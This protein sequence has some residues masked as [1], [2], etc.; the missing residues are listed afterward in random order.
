MIVNKLAELTDTSSDVNSQI[1]YYKISLSDFADYLKID[2]KKILQY[3][4]FCEDSAYKSK[5]VSLFSQNFSRHTFI[6]TI[7]DF[8]GLDAGLLHGYTSNNQYS[9]IYLARIHYDSTQSPAIDET[10]AADE[11][12]MCQPGNLSTYNYI[13][14]PYYMYN[15][16]TIAYCAIGHTKHS[17]LFAKLKSID[18]PTQF[19]YVIIISGSNIDSYG[20]SDAIGKNLRIA[21]LDNNNFSR[22]YYTT[23]IR[24]TSD[25]K[26]ITVE[27]FV[28][29]GYYSDEIF[30]FNGDCPSGLFK[31]DNVTYL[32]IGFNLYIKIVG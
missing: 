31:L 29:K 11:C 18:D 1:N 15:G 17:A 24:K 3:A 22:N 23:D 28:H 2:N 7:N 5:S 30:V 4:D 32:N 12:S 27:K 26:T 16:Q 10:N 19:K 21:I 14:L 20:H 9:G 6:K 13:N 8:S 25:S